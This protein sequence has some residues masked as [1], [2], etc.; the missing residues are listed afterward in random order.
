MREDKGVNE[1]KRFGMNF[2]KDRGL[3]EMEG[4]VFNKN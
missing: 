2:E 3:C 1:G 4:S